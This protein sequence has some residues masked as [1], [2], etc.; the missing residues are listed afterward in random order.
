MQRATIDD[1]RAFNRF[2]T[3][4]LEL[5]QPQPKTMYTM[6][7]KRLLLEI[8]RGRDTA[9]QLQQ[10]LHL[11]KGYLSRELRKLSELV[12]LTVVPD[13]QDARKKHLVL[14]PQGQAALAESNRQADAQIEQLFGQLDAKDLE[15]A[16]NSMHELKR[17]LRASDY[18]SG[19][20]Q[21]DERK[22]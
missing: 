18:W 15:T 10:L 14:T 22:D 11:D 17:V 4:I 12:L 20:Q 3:R 21:E 1:I 5:T 13:T 6:L 8:D 16:L 9:K 19:D 7:E 2:Y